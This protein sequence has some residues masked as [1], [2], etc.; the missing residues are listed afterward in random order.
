LK[1][2]GIDLAWSERNPSGV[3]VIDSEGVVQRASAALQTNDEICQF[4]DLDSAE[5]AVIAIDAPLTVTNLSGQR[6]VEKELNSIFGLYDAAP[7]SANLSNPNF[8][9][10]G[11]IRRLTHRLVEL[12]FAQTAVISKQT[13][14]RVFLEVFPAPSL[15]VLFP[16]HLH[17]EHTHCRP[18]RY[19]YK[20]G[21]HW[22]EVH[23]EWEIY[24]AR[25]RS[26]ECREP[27]LRFSADVRNQTSVDI[28]K[29]KGVRYKAFDDLL[30]G[31]LC[32]YL[33]YYFWHWG[34]DGCRVVGE[35]ATGS[36]TLP[37]CR[38]DDCLL[39]PPAWT[40]PSV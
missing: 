17:T 31:I 20:S 3:A 40:E 38:L 39:I 36:V 21:R 12:G 13:P 18:P 7:H 14:P 30:D 26:L 35:P 19:K 16:C 25:L 8:Q 1:F 15:V 34:E 37:K 24:R 6:P 11:R 5:G 23:S 10:T 32:A 4:A 29:F 33:A 27:V 22:P 28:T 2:V 9:E